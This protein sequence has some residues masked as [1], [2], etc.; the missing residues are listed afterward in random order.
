MIPSKQ[1]DPASTVN[2]QEAYFNKPK[3]ESIRIKFRVGDQ[4]WSKAFPINQ[5]DDF[6]TEVFID[7]NSYNEDMD[8]TE[9]HMP[10]AANNYRRMV[11]IIITQNTQD[12]D[13][14][15]MVIFDNPQVPEFIIRNNTDVMLSTAKCDKSGK[16]FDPRERLK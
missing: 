5:I 2:I 1:I 13:Q 8:V 3:G 15:L 4:M 11:R 6:Q 7:P 14:T 9:W 12:S 10:S 16:P